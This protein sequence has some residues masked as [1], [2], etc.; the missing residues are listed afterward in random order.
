MKKKLVVGLT[1]N[2]ASGKSS[3]GKIFTENGFSVIEADSIGWELLEQEDIKKA[4]IKTF[5]N[6]IINKKVDRK[7]LGNIVFANKNNL[8]KFNQIIH[9]PLLKILKTQIER[10]KENIIVVNAALIFE[11]GIENWFDIIIL[12]ISDRKN[13]MDRLI[14]AGLTKEEALKRI[15]SQMDDKKKIEKSHF[16]IENNESQKELKA[17]TF[18][19]IKKIRQQ[20]PHQSKSKQNS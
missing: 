9:P 15:K 10:N 20:P 3:V 1:G 14:K 7:K 18:A 8:K 17:K 2:I 4:I 11:W 16:V 12:V 5:G 6:V 19:V 13:R